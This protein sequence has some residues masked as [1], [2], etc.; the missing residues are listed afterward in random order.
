MLPFYATRE[1]I[2]EAGNIKG[3]AE[4][5][6]IDR[7]AAARTD[8]IERLLGRHFYPRYE[9][10]VYNWPAV[11]QSPYRL[12][13]DAD[14]I[15]AVVLTSNAVVIADFFEYPAN[16]GPPFSRLEIDLGSGE[17]FQA[18]QTWQR[19][20]AVSGVWGF[21]NDFDAVCLMVD[22]DLNDSATVFNVSDSSHVGIG[23]L[24]KLNDELMIV[25]RSALLATGATLS[26]NV[27]GEEK[28]RVIPV[29][30]GTKF[31]VGET[32][33]IDAERMLIEDV[34][35]DTLICTRNVDAS[36]LA[37]HLSAAVVY[38]PRTL[39]VE[40]GAVGSIVAAHS[41]NAAVLRNVPPG[42]IT[43]LCIAEVL[44]AREQELHGYGRDV[45]QGDGAFELR[46]IG[47]DNLRKRVKQAYTR[48]GGSR[49][50]AI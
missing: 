25:T 41:E 48:S 34:A 14:L 5:A 19:M 45:G 50:A 24:I 29:S 31:N 37:A 12:L 38:A 36:L 9:V 30:D 26:S 16:V 22:A 21:C 44:A 15:E 32:V 49:K 35:G 7:L 10:R 18:G 40:R 8:S 4:N 11:D 47:L 6:R 46:G 1:Q 13:L 3:A 20:I 2:K 42:L 27:D 43:E 23:D 39:T 17:T 33:T 28:T